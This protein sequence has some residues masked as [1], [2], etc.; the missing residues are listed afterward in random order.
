MFSIGSFDFFTP[1]I[2][3][4]PLY[5]L[6][7]LPTFYS[8]SFSNFRLFPFHHLHLT[9]THSVRLPASFSLSLQA[10]PLPRLCSPLH[11]TIM[12][13]VVLLSP[14]PLFYLPFPSLPFLFHGPLHLIP[15]SSFPF[16]PP[17]LSLPLSLFHSLSA[18][19]CSLFAVTAN[20]AF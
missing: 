8:S 20:F 11:S 4:A 5:I 3:I 16:P 18:L 1:L 7:L 2:S 6:S 19:H 13:S 10:P 12:L 14:S 9:S 15:L 17:F